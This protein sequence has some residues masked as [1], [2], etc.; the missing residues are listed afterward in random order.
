MFRGVS[1]LCVRVAGRDQPQARRHI[2]T[3]LALFFAPWQRL[4]Q[5]FRH[6][7]LPLPALAMF[8]LPSEAVIPTDRATTNRIRRM[9]TLLRVL[10]YHVGGS[11]VLIELERNQ[12]RGNHQQHGDL[13]TQ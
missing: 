1:V 3:H 7:S 11:A 9:D 12:R 2:P 5:L 10:A 6:P 13:N 8:V 4:L